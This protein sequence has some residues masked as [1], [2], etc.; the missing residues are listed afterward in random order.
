MMDYFIQF[1]GIVL[2]ALSGTK[3]NVTVNTALLPIW[4][5]SVTLANCKDQTKKPPK[6]PLVIASI[7]PHVA[8]IRVSTNSHPN[9]SAWPEKDTCANVSAGSTEKC[10]V[11]FI[12]APSTITI[13]SG[14]TPATS[15]KPGSTF[16]KLSRLGV[17]DTAME[18][19]AD[20]VAAS[21][22]SLELP[23]GDID[24]IK[25]PTNDMVSAF[26]HV[27]AP[28]RTKTSPITIKAVERTGGTTRTLIVDAGTLINI[29]VLPK[30]HTGMDFSAVNASPANG[31][32]LHLFNTLITPKHQRCSF[33]DL[34]GVC[35][36]QGCCP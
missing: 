14:F 36:N 3:A 32:H 23:G 1:F 34:N 19:V 11:Y 5:S 29:G 18:L 17:H 15:S 31:K 35:S 10:M 33:P 27:V 7:P 13:D 26:V 4:Q 25:M 2:I 21:M 22:A 9:D 16:G 30:E 28:P 8:F 24:V 6:A 20:P 12:P